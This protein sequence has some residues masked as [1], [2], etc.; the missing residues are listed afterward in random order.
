MSLLSSF[1]NKRPAG[2]HNPPPRPRDRNLSGCI[3]PFCFT[4]NGLQLSS[5]DIKVND[6]RKSAILN[7]IKLTFS[8]HIYILQTAH[9]V[10]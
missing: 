1:E 7:L 4:V 9:F 8:G 2:H 3:R 6:Y 5:T 10:L